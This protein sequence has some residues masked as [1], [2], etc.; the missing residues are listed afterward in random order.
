MRWLPL[1]AFYDSAQIP[2]VYF[3]DGDGA[4]APGSA[5]RVPGRGL[6]HQT[7]CVLAAPAVLREGN[8][9]LRPPKRRSAWRGKNS[10]TDPWFEWVVEVWVKNPREPSSP[11]VVQVRHARGLR[12]SSPH[13]NPANEC[14]TL[15][16]KSSNCQAVLSK[17]AAAADTTPG[18]HLW[19]VR[20][21][22]KRRGSRP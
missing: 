4:F 5:A 7:V 10:I 21:S 17:H 16:R 15:R 22:A 9:S 18:A 20:P 1:A 6:Q 19:F 11:A 3:R 14:R 8:R 2:R 12:C 13:P